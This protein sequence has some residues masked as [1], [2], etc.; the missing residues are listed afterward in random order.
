VHPW[1]TDPHRLDGGTAPLAPGLWA[2]VTDQADQ[3]HRHVR[4]RMPVALHLDGEPP[5]HVDHAAGRQRVHGA[6][7][8]DFM[9][10]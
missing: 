9:T 4:E 1:T 8:N 2:A 7:I 10:S 6:H 5:Q 3:L